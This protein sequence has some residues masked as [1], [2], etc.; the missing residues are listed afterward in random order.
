MGSSCDNIANRN[1]TLIPPAYSHRPYNI[2]GSMQL[3]MMKANQQLYACKLLNL[4]PKFGSVSVYTAPIRGERR[5]SITTV[6]SNSGVSAMRPAQKLPETGDE[7]MH[8]KFPG[9]VNREG[10]MKA[11]VKLKM[12]IIEI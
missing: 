8:L 5:W 9:Q 10:L 3:I 6:V 4:P 2:R 11:C 12:Q 1:L 7:Q